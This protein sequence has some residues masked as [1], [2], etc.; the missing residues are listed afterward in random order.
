M[1][2]GFASGFYVDEYTL[3]NMG[4]RFSNPNQP[5][6]NELGTL[7][8]YSIDKE[9]VAAGFGLLDAWVVLI[10]L[11]AFWWMRAYMNKEVATYR[12][13]STTVNRFTV[14]IS[15]LPDYFHDRIELADHLQV[16]FGR[17]FDIVLAY[18]DTGIGDLYI[19]RGQL[20]VKM[21]SRFELQ[22]KR[23]FLALS[24]KVRKLD[25]EI[26]QA[27]HDFGA[28]KT[29]CAFVT[30]QNQESA[31]NCISYFN[32]STANQCFNKRM[33]RKMLFQHKYRLY[34]EFAPEPSNITFQ[35][36]KYSARNVQ[37]RQAC[38][39]FFAILLVI[40]SAAVVYGARVAQA[41]IADDSSLDACPDSITDQE[42]TLTTDPFLI[43][44]YCRKL[45]YDMVSQEFTDCSDF[46]S[47]LAL[48][49]A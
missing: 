46:Y 32:P 6:K 30:F 13:E 33:M 45:G 43:E 2:P 19:K 49:T 11:I 47:S 28:K 37:V 23:G 10:S 21:K 16:L 5:P 41:S 17:I 40:L 35:N 29:I 25:K 20:K 3:G 15:G 44:C 31:A 4:D 9:M 42:I 18:N 14:R 22:D 7:M 27:K 39:N 34:A 36:Y 8:D 26:V 24:K 38:S 48:E 1:D 12:D